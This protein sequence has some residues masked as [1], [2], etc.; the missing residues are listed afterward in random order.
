MK[1]AIRET[2]EVAQRP[3]AAN[4]GDKAGDPGLNRNR[5]TFMT[6]WIDTDPIR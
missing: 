2:I 1:T 3:A 6:G 5:R 4:L